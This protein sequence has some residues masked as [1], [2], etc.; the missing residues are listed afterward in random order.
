MPADGARTIQAD[1]TSEPDR[2]ASPKIAT[3]F[4]LRAP[5]PPADGAAARLRGAGA[6]ARRVVRC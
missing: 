4:A 6:G 2:L 1:A 5:L 3:L